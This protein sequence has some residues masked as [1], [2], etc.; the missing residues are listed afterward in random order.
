MPE[1]FRYKLRPRG[2]NHIAVILFGFLVYDRLANRPF[3]RFMTVVVVVVVVC[4]VVIPYPS[5]CL[6]VLQFTLLLNVTI[7][8]ITMRYLA[9]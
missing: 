8:I 1:K 7:D 3:C 6:C 2:V 4:R 9:S 5:A